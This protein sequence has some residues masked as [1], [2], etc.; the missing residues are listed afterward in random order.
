MFLFPLHFYHSLCRIPAHL[1]YL[2]RCKL[3]HHPCYY[4]QA[5]VCWS[6]GESMALL[7]WVSETLGVLLQLINTDKKCKEQRYVWTFIAIEGRYS[8]LCVE[9]MTACLSIFT[10]EVQKPRQWK[11]CQLMMKESLSGMKRRWNQ[12]NIVTQR[13]MLLLCSLIDL[14]SYESL[15]Y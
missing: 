1:C 13:K 2:C 15:K 8:G 12:V 10:A 5:C 14:M 11:A 7:S 3:Y 9:L 4:H 6:A